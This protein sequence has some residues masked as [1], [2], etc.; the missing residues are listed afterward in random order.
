MI[1]GIWVIF[2]QNLVKNKVVVFLIV[3]GMEYGL[4]F[5]KDGWKC[6]IGSNII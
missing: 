6:E 5:Y 4:D 3:E 1:L 2:R